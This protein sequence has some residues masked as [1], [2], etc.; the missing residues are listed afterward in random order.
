MPKYHTSARGKISICRAKAQCPLGGSGMHYSPQVINLVSEKTFTP[1]KELT[2][3]DV[4]QYIHQEGLSL[5]FRAHSPGQDITDTFPMPLTDAWGKNVPL[6]ALYEVRKAIVVDADKFFLL[7]ARSRGQVTGWLVQDQGRGPV[8]IG[9]IN[10]MERPNTKYPYSV[11]SI[12]VRPEYRGE[13]LAKKIAFGAN[14]V[15]NDQIYSAGHYTPS[16]YKGLQGLFKPKDELDTGPRGVTFE[17]MNFVE[18][19]DNF[20]LPA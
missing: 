6:S 5:P 7:T 18:D 12:E 8:P 16:G 19:W 3:N 13:G 2:G 14:T 10:L 17:D 20:L 11:M 15:L 9:M 1:I 4:E